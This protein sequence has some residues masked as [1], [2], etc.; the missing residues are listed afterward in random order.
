[1]LRPISYTVQQ[2][3]PKKHISKANPEHKEKCQWHMS[4]ISVSFQMWLDPKELGVLEERTIS[5]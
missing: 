3:S 2:H 5:L 4:H 1:M